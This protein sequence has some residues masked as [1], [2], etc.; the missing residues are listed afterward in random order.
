MANA[1]KQT[2][3]AG[4]CR[5]YPPAVRSNDGAAVFPLTDHDDWCAAHIEHAPDADEM[6]ANRDKG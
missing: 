6:F 5:L 1:I 2:W 3:F 4:E